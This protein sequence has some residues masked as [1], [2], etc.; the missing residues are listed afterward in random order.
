M[1]L[2]IAPWD[3]RTWTRGLVGASIPIALYAAANTWMYGAPWRTSYHAILTVKDGV[4][5]VVS[6]SGAFDLPLAQG[7][8]RFTLPSPEG[9]V[10]QMA[11]IPV[12]GYAGVLLLALRRPRLAAGLAVA[13]AAFVIGFGKY[14]YGGARFFMP[15]LALAPIPM[16]A[17]VDGAGRFLLGV[18]GGWRLLRR[19]RWGVAAVVLVIAGHVAGFGTAWILRAGKPAGTPSM[20]RDVESLQVRV[21]DVPCDYLNMAHW[22]WECSGIDRSGDWYAGRAL[23]RQCRG[24]GVPALRVPPGVNGKPRRVEW[25]PDVPLAAVRV[26]RMPEGDPRG[27]LKAELRAGDRLLV[28]DEWGRD[29]LD[30]RSEEF[31]GPFPAGTAFVL[32]VDPRSAPNPALCIDVI[33]IE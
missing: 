11:A 5:Q 6:Y 20:A 21:G 32:T 29:D 24:L 27:R 13:F 31:Q 16:A 25:R 12:V 22:K 33:G 15:W 10:W 3:R 23:A 17:L 26:V 9:E 18:R 14:R 19:S 7:L 28:S 8:R 2:A 4:Q 30:R 1:L